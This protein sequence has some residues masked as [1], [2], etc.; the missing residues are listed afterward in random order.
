[1]GERLQSPGPILW[2]LRL[3]DSSDTLGNKLIVELNCGES[4]G[5]KGTAHIAEIM[6]ALLKR[7]DPAA[8]EGGRQILAT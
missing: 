8:D 3:K 5:I 4:V 1:M 2:H 7:A 6:R